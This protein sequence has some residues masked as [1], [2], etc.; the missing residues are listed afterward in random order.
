MPS[1]AMKDYHAI[2]EV[3]RGATEDE[4]RAAYK[5]LVLKWHPDRHATNK[6]YAKD[7]FVEIH[8]AYR[9]LVER[10]QRRASV[11]SE[12]ENSPS[13]SASSTRSSRSDG[14]TSRQRPS[15]QAYSSRPSET[16]KSD[17][18]RKR[19]SPQSSPAPS[20]STLPEDL[21]RTRRQYSGCHFK[22]D[23]GRAH[24]MGSPLDP[25]S[26]ME[27]SDEWIF[28][29]PLTLKELFHGTRHRYRIT[30][31]MLSGKKKTIVLEIDVEPG[32]RSGTK[33]RLPGVGNERKDGSLQDIVF[34]VEEV[35][36]DCFVRQKDD[37]IAQVQLPR[38][39]SKSSGDDEDE[40]LYLK[41]FGGELF[42]VHVPISP[43][44]ATRDTKV[45]GA[46]MPVRK[47]GKVVGRGDLIIRWDL[48]PPQSTQTSRWEAFKKAMQAIF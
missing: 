32:W 24:K 16:P 11:S 14:S 42:A 9:T 3:E 27:D 1:T 23:D 35:P 20:D 13:S 15:S 46:G 31:N 7:R 30:R 39:D 19:G 25:L 17:R 10:N 38:R 22:A 41:G 6:E 43:V 36:H 33:I 12:K 26:H 8:N 48:S 2:L 37:L 28:P 21:P 5:R 47:G 45:L 40:I 29:L 18:S 34:I 4:I 44:K